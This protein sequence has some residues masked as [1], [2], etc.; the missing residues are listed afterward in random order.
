MAV[1]MRLP[2]RK[3]HALLGD[4]HRQLV[5]AGVRALEELAL[6]VLLV[7]VMSHPTGLASGD[8]KR[9]QE[10]DDR[11]LLHLCS[12]GVDAFNS[13][14]LTVLIYSVAEGRRCCVGR[15]HSC[16]L[17]ASTES[18]CKCR[19]PASVLV[20]QVHHLAMIYVLSSIVNMH[21]SRRN[22]CS[23]VHCFFFIYAMVKNT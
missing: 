21:G 10:S 19:S 17:A 23:F 4:A 5:V 22:V 14:A 16:A 7:P 11:E 6:R 12:H 1:V 20:C 2:V 18:S 13:E 8:D 9:E 3:R 15:E